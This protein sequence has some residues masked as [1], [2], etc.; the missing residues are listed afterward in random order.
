MARASRSARV[1]YS[2]DRPLSKG[3]A[4]IIGWLAISTTAVVVVVSLVAYLTGLSG[5]TFHRLVREGLRR[6]LD[7]GG[8]VSSAD[9]SDS[10]VFMVTMFLLSVVGIIAL[11]LLIGF[12]ATA[13]VG[14]FEDLRRGLWTRSARLGGHASSFAA[15]IPPTPGIWRYLEMP[16]SHECARSP[17][18]WRP[19]TE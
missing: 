11:S 14:K 10:T 4:V 9:P 1:R 16:R 2:I 3:I 19:H 18:G 6:V 8:V 5:T 17:R 13:L 12:V 7:P 15:A